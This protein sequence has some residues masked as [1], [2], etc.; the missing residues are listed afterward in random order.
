VNKL[1][2]SILGMA[3]SAF[4]VKPLLRRAKI[5]T[6]IYYLETIKSV[7]QVVVIVG[8]LIL[9]FVIIAGGAIL[10]PLALCLFMPWQPLTKA[11]VASAFGAVYLLVPTLIAISLMSERRW[12]RATRA[13]ELMKNVIGK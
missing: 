7:R 2:G 12:M 8:A 3:F 9:C 13:D 5:R 11:L 6:A 10:I 4:M 1:F